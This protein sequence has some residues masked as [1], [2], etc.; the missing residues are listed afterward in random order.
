MT[1]VFPILVKR[2]IIREAAAVELVPQEEMGPLLKAV[3]AVLGSNIPFLAQQLITQAA[4]VVFFRQVPT[5]L[6]LKGP[7]A[8]AAAATL[9]LCQQ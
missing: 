9:E 4:V 6:H 2:Q 8:W 5:V 7:E 3:M 1:V